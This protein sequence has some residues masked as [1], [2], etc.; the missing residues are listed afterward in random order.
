MVERSV[1][2]NFEEEGLTE[3]ALLKGEWD[4][5]EDNK[6]SSPHLYPKAT[7]EEITDVEAPN[8]PHNHPGDNVDTL[9]IIAKPNAWEKCVRKPSS[10]I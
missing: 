10:Y 5:L 8:A 2:F 3:G 7:V 4:I 9:E 1:K 6:Q